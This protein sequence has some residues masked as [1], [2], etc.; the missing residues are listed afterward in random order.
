MATNFLKIRNGVSLTPQSAAASPSNGD[1]YYDSGTNTFKMYQGGGWSAISSY[2]DPLSVN[3]DVLIRS[4][5]ATARLP[6]GSS[7]QVLTVSGGLPSWQTPAA[8]GANTALSNLSSVAINAD[9]LPSAD[10]VRS[11]GSNTINWVFAYV[12]YLRVGS[13]TII[14]LFDRVLYGLSAAEILNWNTANTAIFGPGVSIELKGATSGNIKIKAAAVTTATTTLTLPVADGAASTVLSN[15]G[16]G[17]LSWVASGS[18]IGYLNSAFCFSDSSGTAIGCSNPTINGNSKTQIV[19]S[20]NFTPGVS[21]SYTTGD[22][23]IV[24]D[25][26]IIPRFLAGATLD[27]WYKEVTATTN[28]IELWTDLSIYQRSIEIRRKAGTTDTSS[29]NTLIIAGLQEVT[30]GTAAQVTS[31]QAQYS[32]IQAA[33]DALTASGGL[34]RLIG[35]VP[36]ENLIISKPNVMIK[37]KGRSTAIQG[38]VLISITTA[39]YCIIK[40]CRITDNVTM[41]SNKSYVREVWLAPG[42]TVTITGGTLGNEADYQAE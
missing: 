35:T 27:A 29:S 9:L 33:H 15:D 17:N 21:P 5:G 8:T 24:V 3:G 11:L 31:G 14:S 30:A 37:G 4:A 19:L 12:N 39:D 25:G 10:G 23:D 36:A 42:K 16:S 13:T 40:Q 18:G 34:I 20:W 32:S 38:T 1:M 22:I 28:T 2:V 7:G 6:I 26:Q 41:S